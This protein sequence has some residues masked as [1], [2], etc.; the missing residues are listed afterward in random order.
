MKK[1]KRSILLGITYTEMIVAVLAMAAMDSPDLTFPGIVLT[2]AV[3][4]I[5][6]FVKAN[7]EWASKEGR[8]GCIRKFLPRS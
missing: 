2:Q 4:W 1:L 7:P 8:K 5:V 6:L 3:A